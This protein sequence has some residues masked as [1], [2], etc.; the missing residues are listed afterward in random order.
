[1][2]CSK[3]GQEINDRAVVCVHCQKQIEPHSQSNNIEDVPGIRVL[4][5]VGRSGF[6]IAAGYLALFSVLIIPA[7]LALIFGI[8]AIWD[9]KKHKNKHGLGRAYFGV[10]MGALGTMLIVAWLVALIF[11]LSS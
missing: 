8:L 2:F 9:I 10:I 7:P 11:S 6:A 1:M 3:C 4:L 5:P